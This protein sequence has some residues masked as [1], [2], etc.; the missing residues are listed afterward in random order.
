MPRQHRCDYSVWLFLTLCCLLFAGCYSSSTEESASP[1][2]ASE[3]AENAAIEATIELPADSESTPAASAD[4]SPAAESSATVELGD[5]TLTAGIP[6]DGGLSLEEIDTW[7]AD[8]RNHV[9]LDVQLPLS[10]AGAQ[11]MIK[12]LDENPMTR[13][14]IEL[15]RQLYFDTRLSA[16]NTISCASCHDP[17]VGYGK[18]TQFGV[19]VEDQ[20]GNRNSPVAYNRIITDLQF[21][22]GRAELVGRASQGADR[23]PD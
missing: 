7:L 9:P 8:A 20:T 4:E 11:S 16:D 5:P 12:G 13:A 1:A 23:E 21:W 10:L 2:S 14:K 22:D 15:G 6:G 17:A 18:D 3:A 19:G